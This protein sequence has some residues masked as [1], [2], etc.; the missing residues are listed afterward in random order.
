VEPIVPTLKLRKVGKKGELGARMSAKALALS[1]PK[2][3]WRNITW[4]EGSADWLAS[5]FARVRVH[6]AHRDE[7]L[8]VR[9]CLD[10]MVGQRLKDLTRMADVTITD[11]RLAAHVKVRAA[12]IPVEPTEKDSELIAMRRVHDRLVSEG[13][14]VADVH[15]E[16]RGYDLYAT[17]GQAHRCVEVKGVWDSAASQ[18]IRLTGNE[19]LVAT[20]Q[21]I[22]YWLYVI[23]RCSNREP[24][25]FGVYRDPVTTFRVLIKQEAIFRIPGSALKAARDETAVSA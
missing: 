10:Q 6:A 4:R 19:I 5:R 25:V 9:G 12:G 1:L 13:F 3:A 2:H 16:G 17:R 21:R 15:L 22:D 23:D 11:V 18:G 8:K 7:R 24:N 20:Q 14:A